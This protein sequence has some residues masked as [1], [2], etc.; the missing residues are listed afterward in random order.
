MWLHAT[1]LW[2]WTFCFAKLEDHFH[3]FNLQ[4]SHSVSCPVLEAPNLLCVAPVAVSPALRHFTGLWL[5]FFLFALQ[6]LMQG[7]PWAPVHSTADQPTHLCWTS[8]RSSP[9]LCGTLWRGG[10]SSRRRKPS[11]ASVADP[12]GWE[13]EGPCSGL[14]PMGSAPRHRGSLLPRESS[15]FSPWLVVPNLLLPWPPLVVCMS[16]CSVHFYCQTVPMKSPFT[17]PFPN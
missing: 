13:K 7:I 1:S 6:L 5:S 8:C 3:P 16:S 11:H 4:I 10:P 17:F 14:R 12:R 9:C 2:R 15:F